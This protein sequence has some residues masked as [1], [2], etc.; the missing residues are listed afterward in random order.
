MTIEKYLSWRDENGE[1]FTPVPLEGLNLLNDR[2]LNKG[3]AFTMDERDELGLRG[4]LPPHVATLD[5]QV[6]RFYHG[7]SQCSSNI[8]KYVHLRA[9]QDRNETLFYAL[10]DR[11]VEEFTPVIYTPTVGQACQQYS[12]RF[13]KPRGLYITPRNVRMMKNMVHH[14]PSKDIK[15]IV[16][17]DNQGILGIGDQGVGGM[18]IPI[19]KLSL[20]TL[21][22]GIHPASCLPI[23]LD[24]GTD[25]QKLLDN[26]A[27]LGKHNKR[28]VGTEY[29]QFI[30]EFV[31]RIKEF[32]PNA[33]LQWEDFSKANAFKNL[34][35]YQD[36][37][38]SFN[39]D[40]QGTGSVALSGIIGAMKM[41]REQLKDQSF[42]VYGAGAGGVGIAK[43][44]MMALIKEGLSEEEAISRIFTLDSRGLIMK[45][46]EGLDEYKKLFATPRSVTS[47]WKVADS[48]H[49]T[50]AEL[51]NNFRITVLIGTSG[52][53]NSF[54]PEMVADMQ[55][56]TK[57]PVIFPLSNP[58]SKCE[59]TPEQLYQW[60]DGEAIVATGSPF[61]P[62]EFQGKTFRIGQG[63]N[64]F[65][66]PGVGLAA[67]LGGME[68]VDEE[69]FTIA[70]YALA[71]YLSDEDL[72]AGTVYPKIEKLQDVSLFVAT[73]VIAHYDQSGRSEDEITEKIKKWMWKPKYLPYK[74]V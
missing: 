15:I 1:A 18:G 69:V 8:E 59:A 21:G 50:M 7:V 26:P 14:F 9:L 40:I 10:V 51:I 57:R 61:D 19:G 70:A 44:I 46:R 5:E 39:D 37:L 64:V 34:E 53:P 43:Q 54:T 11:Y 65:I 13:Q 3:T 58:T 71:D 67:L 72:A 47:E 62:V 12:D 48:N 30:E 6:E 29:D 36:T 23:T 73:K 74:A 20:Y 2:I 17:T 66:F 63:N 42:L 28:I 45:E 41:K 60:S 35:R 55:R 22:A 68:R 24:V 56:Y 32:F 33:I 4:L 52:Q 31:Y 16:V 49:I 38:P 25:N 27:Y